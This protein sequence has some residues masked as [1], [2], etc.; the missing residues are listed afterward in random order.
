MML[1]TTVL[2]LSLSLAGGAAAQMP[3]SAS[4]IVQYT[5][6]HNSAFESDIA[7]SG[8]LPG[9]AQTPTPVIPIAER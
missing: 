9:P 7:E 2:L 5:G 6:I 8:Y 1:K 4:Q 3:P